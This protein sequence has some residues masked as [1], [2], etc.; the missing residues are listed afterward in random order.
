MGSRA[1]KSNIEKN[2]IQSELENLTRKEPNW[3][4]V[5]GYK[6]TDKDMKCNNYQYQF[7]SNK[8]EGEIQICESGLH[9]CPKLENIF[10]YANILTHRIFEIEAVIDLSY[11]E[12]R[13][14]KDELYRKERNFFYYNSAIY[15][16]DLNKEVAK[17]III[18]RELTEEEIWEQFK[19]NIF[20]NYSVENYITTLE[21]FKECRFMSPEEVRKHCCAEVCKKLTSYGYSE[22]FSNII[23][24]TMVI[25]NQEYDESLITFAKSLY[26]EGL[27]ADMRTYLLLNK[28]NK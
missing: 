23:A 22:T 8:Y 1:L 16:E 19:N 21:K 24:E 12:W 11:R 6:A 14:K 18:Q 9:F 15:V 5:K 28:I 27:S 26:D 3:I 4:T 20:C 25:E 13:I 10:N 17:E 7:G 2:K